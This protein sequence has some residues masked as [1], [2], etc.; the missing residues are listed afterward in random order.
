MKQEERLKLE[1]LFC[2]KPLLK[3]KIGK[4]LEQDLFYSRL[5]ILA[6]GNYDDAIKCIIGCNIKIGDA[7]DIL[8]VVKSSDTTKIDPK[9]TIKTKVKGSQSK[10]SVFL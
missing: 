2:S 6:K 3:E 5:L 10:D 1:R 8:D 7:V 4:L 9:K